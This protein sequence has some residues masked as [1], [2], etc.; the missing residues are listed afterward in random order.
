VV[1][2]PPPADRVAE[3][4]DSDPDPE[5][6][7]VGHADLV[8]HR[9]PGEFIARL[10]Q[11][12]RP[13]DLPGVFESFLRPRQVAFRLNRLRGACDE[14]W[15]S[16]EQA[17]L[18]VRRL[19]QLD[20]VG[21]VQAVERN[22][23]L[24][25]GAYLARQIY[26][27]NPSSV[28]AVELLAPQPGEEVLDLAAA[29]GGKTLLIAQRL[30]GRGRLAAVEA[31][32]PRFFKLQANLDHYGATNVKLY[33][34]DGRTIGGKTPGR[35]DAVLLDAPCSAE[36]RMHVHEPA[37]WGHWSV[38]KVREQARKQLGLLR[39]ALAALKV[40]GRLVYCTCSFAPEENERV[41]ARLL[42]QFRDTVEV[43][44]LGLPAVA[45]QPG[46]TAWNGEDFPGQL[47]HCRRIVPNDVWAGFFFCRLRKISPG[48]AT[49]FHPRRASDRPERNVRA[50]KKR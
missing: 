28:L 38:R 35:F 24:S 22:Q 49:R 36:A 26:V 48:E 18:T 14:V 10:E 17:G 2:S 11:L 8:R 44:P 40:G 42:E 45:A 16:L 33:L 39:S 47:A 19:A 37:S 27:Q 20:D 32:R 41:V 34:A 31:I 23:L 9:L 15:E 21:V 5:T 30:Q 13:E 25:S 4:P 46:L 7:E 6:F 43:E 12:W 3:G 50:G 1:H 29:P